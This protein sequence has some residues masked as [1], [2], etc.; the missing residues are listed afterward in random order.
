[1][2][3]PM[4]HMSDYGSHLMIQPKLADAGQVF[5]LQIYVALKK[6]SYEV[7][8]LAQTGKRQGALNNDIPIY[9]KPT[10]GENKLVTLSN[11]LEV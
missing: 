1:M 6:I 5:T 3:D 11:L 7:S 10:A 8:K 9:T 2:F 4:K